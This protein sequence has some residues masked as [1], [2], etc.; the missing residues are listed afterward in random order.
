MSETRMVAWQSAEGRVHPA[1]VTQETGNRLDLVIFVG[2][3]RALASPRVEK[4]DGLEG[5]RE[6]EEVT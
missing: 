1:L 2:E 6:I 4:F 5:W 3:G